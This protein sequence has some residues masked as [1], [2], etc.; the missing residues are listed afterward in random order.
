MK[1]LLVIFSLVLSSVAFSAQMSWELYGLTAN[2]AEGS[3]YLVSTSSS[4][5]RDAIATALATTGI[6]N[7][8]ATKGYT[9]YSPQTV[10]STPDPNYG[11]YAQNSTP[12]A[13]S[14]IPTDPLPGNFFVVVIKDGLFAVSEVF[15][16]ATQNEMFFLGLDGNYSL[17]DDYWTAGSGTIFDPNAGGSDPAAPEP[18][19]LALLALGVAGVALRRKKMA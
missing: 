17:V 15:A 13:D 18:T 14:T 2:Y 19:V 10:S 5:T 7:N 8:Y 16:C 3:A 6:D 4:V 12:L 1:K 9:S 11:Y